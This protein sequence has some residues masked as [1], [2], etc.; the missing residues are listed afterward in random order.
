MFLLFLL[1]GYRALLQRLGKSLAGHWAIFWGGEGGHQY[2][3]LFLFCNFLRNYCL[4]F[5]ISFALKSTVNR[6]GNS[7]KLLQYVLYNNQ[8]LN[9]KILHGETLLQP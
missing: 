3:Y 7:C 5:K 4:A 9:C 8:Y 6:S 2:H 1:I